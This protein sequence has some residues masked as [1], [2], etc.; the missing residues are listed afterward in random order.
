MKELVKKLKQLQ[1]FDIKLEGDID[2]IL[3][4]PSSWAEKF[5]EEQIMNFVPN[6][7]EAKKYGV[8][9]AKKIVKL[10]QDET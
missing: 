3:D 1:N 5:A 7:I 9:F 8:D 6:Y 10:E 4:N 2:E